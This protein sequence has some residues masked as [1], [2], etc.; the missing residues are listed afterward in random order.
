[1]ASCGLDVQKARPLATAFHTKRTLS[2]CFTLRIANGALAC[3]NGDMRLLITASSALSTAI[4]RLGLGLALALATFPAPATA[5]G[6]PT[7]TTESGKIEGA[8]DTAGSPIGIFR[9][10]PFAAPPVGD[11]RWRE[12]QP[13][14][15][16][17][18]VRDA[19]Q[20]G[21]RCMQQPLFSDMMFRSPAPRIAV[22]PACGLAATAR[23]RWR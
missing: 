17:S 2:A 14:A 21:P 4:P 19:T 3:K 11:L 18:G 10:I 23:R 7:V 20:F 13:V 16:W 1:M 8:A 5:A 6:G 15:H 9:A 22:A 12:P